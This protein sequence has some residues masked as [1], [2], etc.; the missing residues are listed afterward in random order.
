MKNFFLLMLVLSTANCASLS[1]GVSLDVSSA[2]QWN[3]QE[4][5]GGKRLSYQCAD[6]TDVELTFAQQ[7]LATRADAVFIF[8]VIPVYLARDMAEMYSGI[9]ITA[10]VS[11]QKGE[12]SV[13]DALIESSGTKTRP[14]SVRT[15]GKQCTY[16][17]DDLINEGNGFTLKLSHINSCE[18]PPVTFKYLSD[19]NYRYSPLGY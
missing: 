7:R 13:S 6:G 19:F 8:F 14:S 10:S 2:E 18:V 17:W 12:C 11:S 3:I 4:E 9:E 15:Y 5:L 16:K 1:R